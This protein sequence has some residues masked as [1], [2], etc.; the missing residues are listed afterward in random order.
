MII[1]PLCQQLVH[2]S[3]VISLPSERYLEDGDLSNFFCPTYVDV[4]PGY[5]WCHYSRATS[6]GSHLLSGYPLY[7]A[8]IP[9]F[10]IMW[11]DGPNRIVVRQ[12]NIEPVDFRLH[13]FLHEGTTDWNGFLHTCQRFQKLKAFS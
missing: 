7:E 11:Y 5:R 13:R 9:P 6:Q 2:L 1:C 4:H 3:S 10:S 8:I 12:F